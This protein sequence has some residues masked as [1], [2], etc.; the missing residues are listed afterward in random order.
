PGT[1]RDTVE[2]SLLIDGHLFRLIDTAGIRASDDEIEMAGIVRS[3]RAAEQAHIILF[4]SDLSQP[5]DVQ[6]EMIADEYMRLAREHQA[7]SRLAPKII[8]IRNKCDLDKSSQAF[9]T[10]FP[11]VM[12]LETSALKGK[13]ITELE[14]ALA[15][16]TQN[17]NRGKNGEVMLTNL[18]HKQCLERALAALTN[19]QQS[20]AANLSA[21]FV[22][23]DLR[24]VI[25]Q[26]G[27]LV[28][29]VTTEEILGE[30]FS[31]FCIGK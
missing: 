1:T 26:I 29:E 6:D 21:E 28:G 31:H 19:A 12:E 4:V 5:A 10:P 8:H 11:P 16:V 15:M 3:R 24:E 14:R 25:H 20:L 2:D 27:A 13:G 30:I 7:Q 22:A 23:A 18:R 9:Q 17:D